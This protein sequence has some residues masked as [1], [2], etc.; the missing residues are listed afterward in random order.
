MAPQPYFISPW[1][2]FVVLIY[3][4]IMAVQTEMN[5]RNFSAGLEH[6]PLFTIVREPL[7]DYIYVGGRNVLLHFD[8]QLNLIST[9]KRGPEQYTASCQS[10]AKCSQESLQPND[11]KLL[12]IS[13]RKNKLLACG[14]A[15]LGECT[16]H[17]LDNIS[18]YVKVVGNGTGY[19]V[20]SKKSAQ[21]IINKNSDQHADE[22]IYV[23]HQYDAR[24]LTL[25]PPVISIRT[26]TNFQTNFVMKYRYEN[27]QI[28]M[29]SFLDILPIYKTTFLMS[30]VDNFVYK[31]FLYVVNNQQKSVDEPDLVRTIIGR[32]C[33]SSDYLLQS[34][35]ENELH[36]K[37]ADKLYNKVTSVFADL[38]TETLYITA[39][40]TKTGLTVDKTVGTA[41][42]SQK[43][44]QINHYFLDSILNCY[45]QDTGSRRLDWNRQDPR[46]NYN[47]V[48][49]TIKFNG[50]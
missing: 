42:C 32:V 37:V 47:Q 43:L 25:S 35:L 31:G 14:T 2:L 10:N 28:N 15:N 44:P 45:K 1:H 6:S 33:N 16:L 8:S 38:K 23:F 34:Y 40:P 9:F 5:L 3:V 29:Y 48:T 12:A 20:G 13:D 21:L 39:V 49:N 26:L 30:F 36:C 41:L 22:L 7:K 11:F 17:K 46:C 18:D 50:F 27:E 24:N 19:L 4:N